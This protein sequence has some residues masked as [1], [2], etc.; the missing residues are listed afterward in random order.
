MVVSQRQLHR[1]GVMLKGPL[2]GPLK[3]LNKTRGQA[4]IGH[5][6][7]K[8]NN[9]IISVSGVTSI[10]LVILSYR[11]QKVKYLTK[12]NNSQNK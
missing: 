4:N 5:M 8:Q 6:S 1:E 3:G 9:S 10:L 12:Y 2:K 11:T 7:R